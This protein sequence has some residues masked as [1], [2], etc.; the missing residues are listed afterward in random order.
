MIHTSLYIHL[1]KSFY[2]C[3]ALF[4]RERILVWILSEGWFV[5]LRAVVQCRCFAP[6]SVTSDSKRLCVTVPPLCSVSQEIIVLSFF[7][8]LSGCVCPKCFSTS[9]L[10]HPDLVSLG[11]IREKNHK[12][13]CPQPWTVIL[14]RKFISASGKWVNIITPP[15][16]WCRSSGG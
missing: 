7:L 11:L 12:K 10:K 2:S 1:S 15:K 3:L 4:S 13:V 8:S 14:Q 5:K 6:G 9:L 16:D